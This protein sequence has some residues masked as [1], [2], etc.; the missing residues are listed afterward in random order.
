MTKDLTIFRTMQVLMALT[1]TAALLQLTGC[2][3]EDIEPRRTGA[4]YVTLDAGD[5]ANVVPVS[6]ARIRIDGQETPRLTPALITGLDV[7]SHRISAFKPGYVDTSVSVDVM[8]NSADTVRLKTAMATDGAIDLVGAPEGT[9]LLVNHLPVDTVPVTPDSPTLFPNIGIGT[10]EV[11]A[12]LPGHATELPAKWTVQ[13]SP[14]SVVPLS[15]VFTPLDEGTNVGDLAP[16]FN[17]RSD[18]GNDYGI[19]NQRGQVCLVTFFFYNCSACLEEFPYIASTYRDP[20]Y[21]GKIQFF[22]VDFIDSY[23]SLCRFR[24]EH[25]AL[26][27]TFP[28]LHD[29]HQ[30]VKAAYNV[31]N[32]PANF[33]VDATGRTRLVRGGISEAMLRQTLDDALSAASGPTI[34]F[35]MRDTLITYDDVTRSQ[36]HE[37]YGTV[38]NLLNIPRTLVYTVT[39]VSFP[40]TSRQMSVCTHVTCYGPRSGVYVLNE[41]YDPAMVDTAAG[42]IV[43]NMKTYWQDGVGTLDTASFYGDYVMDISVYPADNA[44][45]QITHRLRLHDAAANPPFAV[46]S[47][48]LSFAAPLERKPTY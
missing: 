23:V 5:S 13:T 4:I 38:V 47:R 9:V 2:S 18:W 11:S 19:Q 20:R 17:L 30:T 22:G 16:S 7:G 3:I 41:S 33:I 1:M 46:R 15:P 14:G 21:A 43:Y 34:S 28:L 6:G 24:T 35:V 48:P 32:N 26:G 25:E 8:F 31:F 12:Y 45:E 40:D 36:Y 10:F 29:P 44:S 27:I 42:V 39:P 37:F